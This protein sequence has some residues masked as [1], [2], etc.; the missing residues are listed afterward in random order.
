MFW[1]GKIKEPPK[2]PYLCPSMVDSLPDVVVFFI[3]AVFL[4][5]LFK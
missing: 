4:T 5:W 2:E 1:A 3:N